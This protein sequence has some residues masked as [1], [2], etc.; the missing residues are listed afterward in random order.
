MHAQNHDFGGLC[1]VRPAMLVS[2]KK[3]RHSTRERHGV[4]DRLE[5]LTVDDGAGIFVDDVKKAHVNFNESGTFNLTMARAKA[6][7]S[8]LSYGTARAAPIT[9][10]SGSWATRTASRC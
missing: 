10:I 3:L 1:G 5:A 2:V 7:M 4:P 8:G 9:A 6:S